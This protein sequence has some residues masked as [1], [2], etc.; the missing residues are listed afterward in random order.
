[1]I[2]AVVALAV[3]IPVLGVLL[4]ADEVL[5]RL[6][7]AV[8]SP[9]VPPPD[10]AQLLVDIQRFR[11]EADTLDAAKAAADWLALYDRAA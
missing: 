5:R 11:G 2:L 4:G 8:A 1:M 9:Q 10:A 3:A 7:K 6:Q